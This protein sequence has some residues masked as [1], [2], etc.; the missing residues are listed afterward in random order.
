MGDDY[1]HGFSAEEQTRLTRMQTILNN[2]QIDAMDLRGT[3]RLLDVGSGLGQ[4]TRDFARKLPETSTIIGVERNP[5]QLREARRQAEQAGEAGLVEFRPGDAT[6]LPLAG[7]E[8]GSFDLVHTRF[9]LEHVPEPRRVVGQ[10]VRAARPGGR[11]VLI[12]DDHELLKLWPECE[13]AAR[14]WERYWRSFY[15][16]GFDPLIGR[17]LGELLAG[18]GIED[19]R[20][21]T[22][23]YGAHTGHEL[24]EPVIENLIGVLDGAAGLLHDR[25][26]LDRDEMRSAVSALRRW[27]AGPAASLWYSLPMATGIKP[28]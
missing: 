3:R 11:I 17:K 2:A 9:L 4:L 8:Q 22:V 20:L 12:D 15:S 16:L 6:A 28:A 21:D 14:V 7:D 5:E 26:L 18:E 13:A 25:G 27:A 24:F 19:V 1:I 10:M 23:F